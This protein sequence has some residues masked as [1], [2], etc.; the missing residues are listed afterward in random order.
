MTCIFLYPIACYTIYKPNQKLG[1]GYFK[2][3]SLIIYNGE[4]GYSDFTFVA[5]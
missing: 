2:L 3:Q 5:G 4:R 1:Y